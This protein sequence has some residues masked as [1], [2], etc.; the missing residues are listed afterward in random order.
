[1]VRSMKWLMLSMLLLVPQMASAAATATLDRQISSYG[2]SVLLHIRVDESVDEDPDFNVLQADFEILNQSQS[3]NYSIVNGSISRSKQWQLN[4][5]PKRMGVLQIPAIS[6]GNVQ[7]NPLSLRVLN[8][9]QATSGSKSKDIFLEV[10]LAAKEVYVQ[11]QLALTVKLFRAVNLAQAELSEPEIAQVV[12]KK[13]GEDKTYETVVNQRRFIVTER[14]YALFP[15]EAGMLTIPA[16][17][18]NG[19]LVAGGRSMF[20]QQSG[21]AVRVLSEP[22]PV[23][24]LA[25]PDVWGKTNPWLPA[26]ALSLRELWTDGQDVSYKVGEPLTRTIELRAT[27]LTAAHLPTLF[28]TED[29]DGFKQY[30]DQPLLSSETTADGLVAIRQEKVAL[31]PT[32]AGELTLP[33][34]SVSWWDTQTKTK[35]T[36]LI[37]ARVIDVLPADKASRAAEPADKVAMQ[38]GHQDKV[39]TTTAKEQVKDDHAQDSY[40]WQGLTLFFA[41]IWLLTLALWWYT[42]RQKSMKAVNAVQANQD[43]SPSLKPVQKALVT[44]C[45]QHDAKKAIQLLPQWASLFFEEK[46]LSKLSQIKGKSQA[47]DDALLD[48]ERHLYAKEEQATWEGDTLLQAIESATVAE[49]KQAETQPLKALYP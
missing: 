32:R 6:F 43:I 24:V 31:I 46:D 44:A 18:F 37:P 35:Q 30:P 42:A 45:K 7:T 5:M 23:Q 49:E 4:L 27:G 8:P 26:T 11:A 22:V 41:L 3:S 19:R 16:I 47:L 14:S 2:E 17:Q 36:A 48:L 1:M 29:V 34:V 39:E 21:R 15:S 10:T 33:G 9:Q 38:P 25:K 40:W 28:K 20:A 13:L 12:V